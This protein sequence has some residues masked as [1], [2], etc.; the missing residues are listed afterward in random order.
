MDAIQK[1]AL[2]DMRHR[3][4]EQLGYT[5]PEAIGEMAKKGLHIIE[6][7]DIFQL[8]ETGAY[9]HLA[10]QKVRTI[11]RKSR[12]RRLSD[13][14]IIKAYLHKGSITEVASD[15]SMS[16]CTIGKIRS[17]H[18]PY[19]SIL[20]KNGVI[21]RSNKKEKTKIKDR[22]CLK[23]E[24]FFTPESE[25][26]FLCKNCRQINERTPIEHVYVIRA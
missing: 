1:K 24:T 21:K 26:F 22:E 16:T 12:S 18:K 3:K 15:C 13:E 8:S 14:T 23:C 5:Y 4:A 17:L 19:R 11:K 10:K 9:Y 2:R 7:C 6:I 20:E 25:G